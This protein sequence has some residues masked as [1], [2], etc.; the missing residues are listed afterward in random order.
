MTTVGSSRRTSERWRRGQG[1]RY[2]HR[3][4]HRRV[5]RSE[6]SPTD[7]LRFGP[8]VPLDEEETALAVDWMPTIGSQ[9][10][11]RLLNGRRA[12]SIGA[13]TSGG[14]HSSSSS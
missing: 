4:Y 1:A 9:S 6:I 5:E 11:T 14:S 7:A 3:T 13:E 12:P 2:A 8:V 10:P